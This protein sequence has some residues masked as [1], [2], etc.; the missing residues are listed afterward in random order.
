MRGAKSAWLV[1]GGAGES[2]DTRTEK[3][4]AVYE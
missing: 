3:G 1:S 4:A 2:V